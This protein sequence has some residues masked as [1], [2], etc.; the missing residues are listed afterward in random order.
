MYIDKLKCTDL[1]Q[2]FL[3]S[4]PEFWILL[5]SPFIRAETRISE[6]LEKYFRSY[7]GN[8]SLVP[9]SGVPLTPLL[10]KS[11]DNGP[12]FTQEF[13][14]EVLLLARGPGALVA[15]DQGLLASSGPLGAVSKIG[16]AFTRKLLIRALNSEFKIRF[17]IRKSSYKGIPSVKS[18]K[19]QKPITKVKG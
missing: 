5:A 18:W 10:S 4:I 17:N 16:E 9:L 3:R 6:S 2:E 8:R 12:D 19:G 15:K 11:K 13:L 1:E 14:G 7:S